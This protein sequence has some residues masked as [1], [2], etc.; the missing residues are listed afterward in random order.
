MNDALGTDSPPPPRTTTTILGSFLGRGRPRNSS[1]SHIDVAAARELSPA[2]SPQPPS[3]GLAFGPSNFASPHTNNAL[4]GN[5]NTNSS[6]MNYTGSNN[7][8]AAV[9]G[10]HRHRRPPPTPA[11]HAGGASPPIG[12]L[13]LSHMLRRRRS[14]G[15]VPTVGAGGA[16]IGT[17]AVGAM[18]RSATSVGVPGSAN[19]ALGGAGAGVAGVGGIG[20]GAGAGGG[21]GTGATHRIRL[22]PHLDSRRS[23]RFDPIARDL[24]EAEPA[25]R[26]GRFTDRC[27]VLLLLFS[28]SI[29]LFLFSVS[30]LF[31]SLYGF[32]GFIFDFVSGR[33]LL[34]ACLS[35]VR[36]HRRIVCGF[37]FSPHLFFPVTLLA[38][39][40]SC[41]YFT[42]LSSCLY[43]FT[44]LLG[45]LLSF[46]P[47][48]LLPLYPSTNHPFTPEAA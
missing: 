42:L 29:L 27:V 46:L 20:T 3:P 23:L 41:I 11:P 4:G 2:A 19:P 26:I 6:S 18:P 34:R 21:G 14:A 9:G 13:N 45:M 7:P 5:A 47:P 40:P 35:F 44:I 8:F 33:S 15:N 17:G 22:V 32:S 43:F 16:P 28:V 37:G 48:S 25:L 24:K 31:F 10:S 1:Q 39:L 30:I 38:D 12:G 36:F